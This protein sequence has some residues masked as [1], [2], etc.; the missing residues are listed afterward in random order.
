MAKLAATDSRSFTPGGRWWFLDGTLDWI[1]FQH[2]HCF[3]HRALELGIMAGHDVFGPVFHIN[4][5][6]D[7]FVLH[8]PLVVTREETAARRDHRSAINEGWCV[9]CMHETAPGSLAHK[10]TNSS[11]LK[12]VRHQIASGA[13]HLINDHYFWAPDPGS[14]TGERVT[15][16]GNVIEVAIKVALQDVNDVVSR[17]PSAVETLID[18][19]TFFVLLREVVTI[20]T[21]VPGL[22]CVGEINVSKLPL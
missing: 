16:A 6:R 20:K 9:G 10:Q 11:S 5:R 8:C 17:R 3:L 18:H 4:I 21:R 2:A 15:I 14:G 1:F 13:R 19:H 7:T 12:H 22:A